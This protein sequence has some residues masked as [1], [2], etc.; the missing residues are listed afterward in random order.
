M[1]NSFYILIMFVVIFTAFLVFAQTDDPFADIV[2]PIPGLGNCIDKEDCLNYC[3]NPDNMA[4]CLNFAEEN[5]LVPEKD[6][7]MGRKMLVAGE[8]SGPGGCQG[9]S[10]CQAYC[11]DISHIRE[12]I[13]FA[14]EHDLIP[15]EE[16]AEARK[17]AEAIESG[18][19]PP[20]C[21]SKS[22][23]DVVCRQPENM[24]VCLAFAE[25]AGLIPPEELAE[26][27]KVLAAI[28]KGVTPPPCGNKDEC[29]EYCAVPENFEQCITF[30]EAAGFVS[31]EEATMARRTGG[32]GPGDCRG[33]EACEAFCQD[34]AN[35]EAC[36]NFAEEFGFM[37]HEEAEQARKMTAAGINIMQGGPGGCKGKEACE[38][39]CDDVSH[40]TE[41]VDFAVQS[42]MMSPEDAERAKKMAEKGINMMGGGP[43]GCKS[44]EACRAFCDDSANMEEC[45]NFAVQIGEMTPE[46][47]EQAQRGRE[48]M[49]QGGPGGCTSE[50]ECKAYCEDPSHGEEC[51]K[52]SVEAGIMSPEEVQQIQQMQLP[53][54]GMM[55]KGMMPPEGFEGEMPEEMPEGMAPEEFQ[56]QFQEQFEQQMEQQIQQQIEQQMQEQIQQQMEEFSPPPTSEQP[57]QSFFETVKNFLAGLI[58]I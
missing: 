1:K 25:A 7:E 54:E 12:C 34:P 14:E 13:A 3:E 56:E 38:A 40:M 57:P 39:Y 11:D 37:S 22:E 30:A 58:G 48:M 49:M 17:V 50:D 20:P 23:C 41:C 6:I 31:P 2:Y 10:E 46:E 9:V 28:E 4:A 53:E 55:P 29:D 21:N 27:R 24:K 18:V 15:P 19:T 47:A 51:F 16:L 36:I 26:A 33:K 35:S 52:F 8:T 32:K 45:M 42:G 44:E 43:G 5:G